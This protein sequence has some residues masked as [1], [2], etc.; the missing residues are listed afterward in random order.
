[1]TATRARSGLQLR[2]AAAPGGGAELAARLRD[3]L[4]RVAARC[5][6]ATCA[7]NDAR[8]ASLMFE[9]GAVW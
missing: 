1:M 8:A 2:R 3:L 6:T 4:A 5:M 9:E 7:R